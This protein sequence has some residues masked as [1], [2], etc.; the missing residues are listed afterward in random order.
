MNAP[1]EFDGA[2]PQILV[3]STTIPAVSNRTPPTSAP[4]PVCEFPEMRQPRIVAGAVKNNPPAVA[5]Q[6]GPLQY[7]EADA[8]TTFDVTVQF[9]IS[10]G[11]LP[12][13]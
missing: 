13:L 1:V 10:S 4:H 7:A 5:V 11:A 2:L 8:S 6:H 12:I 3:D 9:S